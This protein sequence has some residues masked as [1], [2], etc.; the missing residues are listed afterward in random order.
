LVNQARP[1]CIIGYCLTKQGALAFVPEV[2]IG[3]SEAGWQWP[4][5]GNEVFDGWPVRRQ[6]QLPEQFAKLVLSAFHDCFHCVA[7]CEP[8]F[9]TQRFETAL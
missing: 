4:V 1:V 6:A 9:Q 7:L 3:H 5:R 2:G 8:E